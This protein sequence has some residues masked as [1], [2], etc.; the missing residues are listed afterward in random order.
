M[1]ICERVTNAEY[2]QFVITRAAQS[3]AKPYGQCG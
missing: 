3:Y 2:V 1:Q